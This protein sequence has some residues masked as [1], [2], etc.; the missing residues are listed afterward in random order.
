MPT[1]EITV[2][3]TKRK[4][5]DIYKLARWCDLH[6]TGC[7]VVVI[8]DVHSMPGNSGKSMFSFGYAAGAVQMA[9]AACSAPM[10]LIGPAEWKRMF[11]VTAD[12]DSSRRRASQLLP[13]FSH[14]W[15]RVKDDGRAEAALLAVLGS[16]MP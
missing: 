15:E 5:L 9:V 2:G 10:H 6:L 4:R 13:P 11:G 3:R 1:H 12:K 14:L 7:K 8:E 16:R